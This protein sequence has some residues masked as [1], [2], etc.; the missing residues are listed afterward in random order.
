MSRG[1]ETRRSMSWH[2]PSP[3]RANPD[4][5]PVYPPPRGPKGPRPGPNY[6]GIPGRAAI[7]QGQVFIVA[8]IV[9]AQLWLVP[10]ALYELLSGRAGRLG[11]LTLVSFLGCVLALVV[12]LWPRRRL[13]E[14]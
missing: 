10:D 6:L 4:D 14:R 9:I 12:T 13:E 5:P 1:I 8:I 3:P 11:W 7:V 2:A